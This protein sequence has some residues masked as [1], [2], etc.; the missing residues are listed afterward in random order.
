MTLK[1]IHIKLTCAK[2]SSELI[3]T[4]SQFTKL[5]NGESAS[6]LVCKCGGQLTGIKEG[7]I[8]ITSAN[9]SKARQLEIDLSKL[10]NKL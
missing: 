5:A 4:I 1:G 3:K 6:A 9:M 7:W 10:R 2:C 8:K